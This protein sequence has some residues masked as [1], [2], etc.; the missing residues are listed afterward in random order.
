MLQAFE[1]TDS[2]SDVCTIRLQR[3]G[4]SKSGS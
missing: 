3:V 1:I 4:I 2:Y